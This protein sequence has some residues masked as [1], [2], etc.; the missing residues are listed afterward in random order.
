MKEATFLQ[1]KQEEDRVNYL[2]RIKIL[3]D[4][5]VRTERTQ[6]DAEIAEL[7][8]ARGFPP[9]TCSLTQNGCE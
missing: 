2:E 9:L 8:V 5:L 4:E 1:E 6:R 7:V 3:E